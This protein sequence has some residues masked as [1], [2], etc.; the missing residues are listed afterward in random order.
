MGAADFIVAI[1]EDFGLGK[2]PPGKA[3]QDLSVH[4][5]VFAKGVDNF[6]FRELADSAA[7]HVI[8]IVAGVQPAGAEIIGQAHQGV[9]LVLGKCNVLFLGHFVDLGLHVGKN[10]SEQ[11][12]GLVFRDFSGEN[13]RIAVRTISYGI[14][15]AV[16]I[17]GASETLVIFYERYSRLTGCHSICIVGKGLK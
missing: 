2:A 10:A 3:L 14:S 1:E 4:V 16:Y 5:A 12:I 8:K 17:N 6:A 7:Q 13:G 9:E 15:A 11:L